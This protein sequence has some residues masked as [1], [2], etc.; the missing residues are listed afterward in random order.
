M[1]NKVLKMIVAA[2][3]AISVAVIPG[4]AEAAVKDPFKDVS[5]N[6][7][8]YE[9]VHEMR[10]KRIIS[11][12]ENGEFRP[13]ESISRKHA[14][15]LVNRATKLKAVE[16]FV[17]FKDVSPKNAFF[18]DIKKLQQAGIFEPDAKGNLYPNQPITR[19]EMAKVLT[20]AYDLKVKVD[21]DFLDVPKTHPA[22]KYIKALYSNG[23]TTGDYGHY[24]PDKPVTR[25]HY[26][27]FLHRVLH[28]NDPI[29]PSAPALRLP[30]HFAGV[31]AHELESSSMWL[32][33]TMLGMLEQKVTRQPADYLITDKLEHGWAEVNSYYAGHSSG[34]F[35]K[36]N[37][38]YLKRFVEKDSKLEAILD[39]WL[40]GDF[41]EL[42]DDYFDL[43]RMSDSDYGNCDVCEGHSDIHIR[44]Q[45]AEEYFVLTLYGEEGLQR[46]REQWYEGK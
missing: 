1:K 21:L 34:Q 37:I 20:I 25:V 44:T 40:Q 7:P 17:P 28:M 14:A 32:A 26:A 33:A 38:L 39:K 10:D 5:K 8:Y 18:N 11:G 22:S 36:E 46:H 23:I 4:Q 24:N 2:S 29:D 16:P 3:I 27:V 43:R 9:M 12:Y 31:P 15:A 42:K 30:G 6:N 41:S 13:T 45:K 19:A 35:A